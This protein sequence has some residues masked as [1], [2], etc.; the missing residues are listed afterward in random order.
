MNRNVEE[1][2]MQLTAIE[3]IKNPVPFSDR[4]IIS[5]KNNIYFEWWQGRPDWKFCECIGCSQVYNL[6]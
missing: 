2:K 4:C 6:Y 5:S 3:K 1:E